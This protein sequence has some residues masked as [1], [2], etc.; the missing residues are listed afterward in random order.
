MSVAAG[1]DSSHHS[2]D[3]LDNEGLVACSNNSD[4]I[5]SDIS[6]KRP[7]KT[8][9]YFG[10]AWVYRGILTTEKALLHTDSDQGAAD[11]PFPKVAALLKTHWT[12]ACWGLDPEKTKPIKSLGFFC[13]LASLMDSTPDPNDKTK[14]KVQIRAFL[15][16]KGC[17]AVAV[18]V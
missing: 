12:G 17:K 14:V 13:N 15:Q 6:R 11:G 18:T 16:S 9:Q 5:M 3:D 4:M 7:R 8:P 10:T 2:G 1:S